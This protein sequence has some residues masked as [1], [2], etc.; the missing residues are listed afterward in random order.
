MPTATPDSTAASTCRS[1][2]RCRSAFGGTKWEVL[3]GV[4]NLFRDPND[5][6]RSTTN[7]SSSARPSASSAASWSGS[8]EL[9]GAGLEH[10]S[11]R[12][13]LH[14]D[15]RHRFFCRIR[16][17]GF[18]NRTSDVEPSCRSATKP[19][20]RQ[21]FTGD[22]AVRLR[23]RRLLAHARILPCP[24]AP[25]CR[26]ARTPGV[27]PGSR[28]TAQAGR[29]R[30]ACSA[31]RSRT[32]P[33]AR[34]G[35]A[36]GRRALAAQARRSWP[37]EIVAADSPAARAG[38]ARGRHPRSRST[39]G[40]CRRRPATS[41]TSLHARAPR[42]PLDYTIAAAAD[43][44]QMLDVAVA[45]IPSGRAAL[46]YALAAVGIF[47]LLVGASVRLRRPGQP[48]DAAL[49]LADGRVLRR[50][51]VLVQRPAR[52]L[53]WVFYW[54][55]VVGAAAAAAAL[56]ALRA[57]LPR[58]AGQLGAQ[59][60]RPHAAAAALPAGAAARRRARRGAAARRA[61]RATC[62]RRVAHAASSAASC[63]TSRS[64][65]SPGWRS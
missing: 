6:A 27:R 56:P 60:R 62:C 18:W 55:D 65:W 1:T 8:N 14:P 34:P 37:R 13:R 15:F 23:E 58:A 33:C 40:R 11:S 52:P 39:A 54:G 17:S 59:R 46:Y 51:R 63:S 9:G 53:D 5:P 24:A 20:N 28:L 43:R 45:P 38:L 19:L 49:L 26:F 12:R 21:G 61:A 29:R 25:T 42:R 16:S 30:R 36:R 7:C 22:R 47:S 31:W 4:R 44:T 2:R 3:V 10:G 50:A 32:S 35:R 48:G 57:R 41:S 64:A